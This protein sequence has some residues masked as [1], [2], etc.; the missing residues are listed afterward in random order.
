MTIIKK[1]IYVLVAGAVMMM[2][3]RP[4]Q[5]DFLYPWSA[6]PTVL[7]AAGEP[8]LSN[9]GVAVQSGQDILGAWHAHEG[10]YHYFR[11]DLAQPPSA[12]NFAG[13]Y[14]IYID[15]AAAGADG[16]SIAYVPDMLTGIDFIVDSHYQSDMGGWLQDDYH[17]W[18]G[19]DSFTRVGPSDPNAPVGTFFVQHS[20]NGGMTLEW[21][22]NDLEIGETIQW[23]AAT[24]DM[25]SA[26]AT[27]DLAASSVPI[28]GAAWLLFSGLM[29]LMGLK[30][31][32][33]Y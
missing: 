14:G 29:G 30:K 1:G 10:D 25:G 18:N 6:T 33:N 31:R 21:K 5:A 9:P 20:E 3:G 8:S 17:Q 19:M 2:Y 12:G 28:P 16:P 11:I 15:S 22:V 24:H 26:A 32:K 4:A 7:D 23:W 13:L 27:Y